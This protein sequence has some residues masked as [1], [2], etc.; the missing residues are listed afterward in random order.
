[1]HVPI[2]PIQPL[3]PLYPSF[4]HLSGFAPES[5]PLRLGALAAR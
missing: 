3:I 1:M 4:L 2:Y 5:Y